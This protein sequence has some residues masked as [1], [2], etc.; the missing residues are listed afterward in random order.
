MTSMQDTDLAD[1]RN[2]YARLLA[3]CNLLEGIADGLPNDIPRV[4]CQMLAD[5]L[6]NELEITHTIED[7]V[8]MPRLLA[9]KLPSLRQT[10]GRLRQEHELDKQAAME[11]EDSLCDLIVGGNFLSAD[12]TGYLL[13][14][15]FESVRRHVHAEQNLLHM[16]EVIAP[17]NRS[18]H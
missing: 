7:Q 10:A 11:V 4:H 17:N 2:C 13:R 6:V 16:M 5:S 9:T 14:S 1:L 8:L 12:A 18:L 3:I 15:F